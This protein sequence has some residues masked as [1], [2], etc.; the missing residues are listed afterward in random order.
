MVPVLSI[1]MIC[2]RPVSSRL[3]AV[4]NRIPFLA[5]S[6]L[7]TMIA[8][9]VARPRAQGQLMTSTEM[10]R[11]SAYPK[12]RPISI[13]TTVV[14]SA[15]AMTTG[16]KTPETLSAILAIGALVAA[17]SLTIL[18]IWE[19]VVSSPTRVASQRR[20]PDWLMVA[21]DTRSP[22]DLSTGMLSPVSAD[23]FTALEPSRILPSTGMLSPG[24]TRKMSPW[25][26]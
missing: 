25:R 23:S 4:L 9:G 1:T 16:T 20:K 18:M 14:T 6:P 3:T 21:A 22:S 19:R 12:G 5:P 7:P 26:T 8:T 24:R 10:P 17:A 15:M 11:A 2:V 13:Q